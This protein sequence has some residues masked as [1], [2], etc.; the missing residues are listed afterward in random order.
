M[1]MEWWKQ[2]TFTQVNHHFEVLVVYLSIFSLY[3]F[4]SSQLHFRSQY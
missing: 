3:Y 4:T 2:S 1:V